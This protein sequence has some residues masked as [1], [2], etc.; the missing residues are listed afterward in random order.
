ML[1][2]ILIPERY[3]SRLNRLETAV[4]IQKTKSYFKTGF[5]KAL[6]LIEVSSPVMVKE[7]TGINDNLNGTE[8]T[9]SFDVMDMKEG[10]V[11]IV[12]SLAKWKRSALAQYGFTN[13]EGL[14]TDMK[15][16][17][18]DENM[19]NLHSIYVDQWD[20]EKVICDDMRTLGTLE[21]EVVGTSRSYK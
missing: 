14:Y 21:H 10:R 7:G 2:S 11:E 15:A 8:R 6:R 3:Q 5:E 19:D 16:V 20:W 1:R 12:Q 9:V 4:A 18:R 13:G 17:R